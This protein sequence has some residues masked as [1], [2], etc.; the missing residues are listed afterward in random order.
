MIIGGWNL[1]SYSLIQF[2]P[3]SFNVYL[4]KKDIYPKIHK[5]KGGWSFHTTIIGGESNFS[6]KMDNPKFI[7]YAYTTV[8]SF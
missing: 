7:Y 5:P 1:C 3:K 6:Y 2:C 4:K 8:S